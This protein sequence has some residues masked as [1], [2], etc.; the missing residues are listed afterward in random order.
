M[1]GAL[2]LKVVFSLVVAGLVAGCNPG[3]PNE[4][5]YH[6]E[7]AAARVEKDRFLKDDRE[8]PVPADRKGDF[9]PLRYYP[10]EPAFNIPAM[11]KPSADQQTISMPTSAGTPTRCN[12]WARSNLR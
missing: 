10:I 1:P 9:L 12:G 4:R 3:P 5:G 11:L 2:L 6:A 7:I 8:S